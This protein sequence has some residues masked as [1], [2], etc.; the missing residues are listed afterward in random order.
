[1]AFCQGVFLKLPFTL[2]KENH[3]F[4]HFISTLY[5]YL[6]LQLS[7]LSNDNVHKP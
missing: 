3:F 4:S 2:H 1:M 7:C 5:N 6:F